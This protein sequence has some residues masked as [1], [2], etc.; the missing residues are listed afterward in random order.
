[1][2]S[3]KVDELRITKI[4]IYTPLSAKVYSDRRVNIH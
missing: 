4:Q 2:L 1:M 3:S